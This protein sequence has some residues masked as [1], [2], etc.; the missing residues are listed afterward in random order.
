MLKILLKRLNLN[1]DSV[2]LLDTKNQENLLNEN[3]KQRK[4]LTITLEY[5]FDSKSHQWSTV[6]D[7]F[8]FLMIS[9]MTKR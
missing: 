4:P 2:D 7:R 9:L 5:G 8:Y 3:L 1:V 6:S